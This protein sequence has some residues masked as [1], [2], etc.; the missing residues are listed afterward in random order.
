MGQFTIIENVRM[1][2]LL[3]NNNIAYLCIIIFI[4]FI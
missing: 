2:M 1:K 4:F 3:Q